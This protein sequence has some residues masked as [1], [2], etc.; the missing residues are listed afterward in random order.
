MRKQLADALAA[1]RKLTSVETR[2]LIEAIRLH[3]DT[4]AT[5]VARQSGDWLLPGLEHE[6]RRRGLLAR[7][8]ITVEWVAHLSPDY[9][10]ESELVRKM[11]K[12]KLQKTMTHAELLN[13]GRTAAK[14]LANYVENER[15]VPGRTLGPRTLF[16]HVKDIPVALNRSFPGYVAGGM[17]S[18]L[19]RV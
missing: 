15:L 8:H 9:V 4:D 19:I 5:I 10:T 3:G 6:L 1:V 18:A 2:Q 7:P 12:S 14:A 16:Q 13:L 17:L 11:L